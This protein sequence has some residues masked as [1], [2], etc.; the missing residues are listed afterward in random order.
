MQRG[1]VGAES[2]TQWANV[3]ATIPRR[4]APSGISPPGGQRLTCN[5]GAWGQQSR[6]G[7]PQAG[8]APLGGSDSHAMGERGGN[9]PAPGRPKRD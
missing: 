2:H 3:G 6:A 9:N 4:A 5:G 7:P 1:S 8:L